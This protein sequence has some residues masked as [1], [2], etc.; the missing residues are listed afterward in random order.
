MKIVREHINEAFTEEGDPIIDMDIGGYSFETLKPGAV[1]KAKRLGIAVTRNRSGHFTSW[2]YG[3]RLSPEQFILVYN[4]SR[5]GSVKYKEIKFIKCYDFEDLQNKRENL[6][7]NIMLFG[8]GYNNRMI[9]SKKMF[10]NRF[11]VIE[12]GF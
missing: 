5:Y 10:D 7:K 9:V 11:E 4:V 2:H 8:F 12:R 1:I 6:K 3:V